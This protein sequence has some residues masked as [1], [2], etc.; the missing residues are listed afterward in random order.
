MNDSS[1]LVRPKET[2]P[3]FITSDYYLTQYQETDQGLLTD[4]DPIIGNHSYFL[5]QVFT[6]LTRETPPFHISIRG[7]DELSKIMT[8][9][10]RKM[11]DAE[12]G[13]TFVSGTKTPEVS[14]IYNSQ[15][16]LV[17]RVVDDLLFYQV[18][19]DY[20]KKHEKMIMVEIPL[21]FVIMQEAPILI[22]DG[23]INRAVCNYLSSVVKNRGIPLFMDCA[24]TTSFSTLLNCQLLSS[25][26]WL[27]LNETSI[28]CLLSDLN[29][30]KL[31]KEWLT[32]SKVFVST[33]IQ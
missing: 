33:F 10:S 13:T 28:K 3:V 16:V 8:E 14:E 9:L 31:E 26:D 21:I 22:T 23:Q 30:K 18:G 11:G 19:A 17:N 2:C 4:C 29:E 1:Y 32:L 15:G 6:S 27:V 25:C 12:Y 20:V 5:Y 7:A 24:E